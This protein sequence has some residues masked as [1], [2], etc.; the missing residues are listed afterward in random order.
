MHCFITHV[1]NTSLCIQEN[2]PKIHSKQLEL[3]DF[4]TEYERLRI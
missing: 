3:R 2:I 4:V 1:E